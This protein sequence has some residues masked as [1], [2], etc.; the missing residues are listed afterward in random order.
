[1]E[2]ISQ[3]KFFLAWYVQLTTEISHHTELSHMN[4]RFCVGAQ[5]LDSNSST[6]FLIPQ[7]SHPGSISVC[8]GGKSSCHLGG[9][10]LNAIIF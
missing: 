4:S 6:F 8:S 3:L 10:S 7:L 9:L 1:M 2:A 5:G